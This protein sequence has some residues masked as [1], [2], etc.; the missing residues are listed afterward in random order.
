MDGGKKRAVSFYVSAQK[1]QEL[2]SFSDGHYE[3]QAAAAAA[4]DMWRP[5]G[6]IRSDIN[7]S[8]S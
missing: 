4:H 2:A 3:K 1:A 7:G 8:F 6:H 5:L